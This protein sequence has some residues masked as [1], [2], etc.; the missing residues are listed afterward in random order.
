MRGICVPFV[1]S[2]MIIPWEHGGCF[3][4]SLSDAGFEFGHGFVFL[5]KSARI[6]LGYEMYGWF[7]ESDRNWWEENNGLFLSD[8]FV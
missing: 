1:R 8:H 6:T 4:V 3:F 2:Q 5:S 7:G